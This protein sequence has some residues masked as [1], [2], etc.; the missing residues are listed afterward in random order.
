MKKSLNTISA[1][2]PSTTMSRKSSNPRLNCQ[3]GVRKEFPQGFFNGV[4]K[5]FDSTTGYYHVKYEDGDSE[6]CQKMKLL[7]LLV[8]MDYLRHKD[9]I[10]SGAMFQIAVPK[11][12]NPARRILRACRYSLSLSLSL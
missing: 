12:T 7:V 10:D 4:L 9:A 2:Q 6:E 8:L 11:T 5:G 3:L 1:L